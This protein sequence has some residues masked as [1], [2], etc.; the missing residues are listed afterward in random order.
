MDWGSQA[1]LAMGFYT[2]EYWSGLQFP[3][4]GD[5]PD[6]WMN[7]H[8]L[9]YRKILHSEPAGKPGILGGSAIKNL[10]A[11]QEMRA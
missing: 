11:M 8:L 5:L 6:P 7:P 1:L 4:P 3:T 10:S 9:H 2:Q